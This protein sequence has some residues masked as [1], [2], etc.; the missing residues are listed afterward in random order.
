VLAL[1]IERLMHRRL[2]SISVRKAIDRLRQIKAGELRVG[3]VTTKT[4]MRVTEEQQ[5]LFKS[6]D[7]PPPRFANAESL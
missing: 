7:V 5:N 3:G 1:Q 6:L 4:L 2:Q